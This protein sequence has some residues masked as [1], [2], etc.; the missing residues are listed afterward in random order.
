[1]PRAM[2]RLG[3]FLEEAAL[4]GKAA[5]VSYLGRESEGDPETLETSP[6][7]ELAR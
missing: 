1:M 5:G 4:E 3:V 7:W 2:G 6:V